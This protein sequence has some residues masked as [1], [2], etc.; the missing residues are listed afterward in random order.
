VPALERVRQRVAVPQS[1]RQQTDAQ[2]AVR[3]A[4]ERQGLLE[5]ADAAVRNLSLARS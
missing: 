3:I 5:E 1:P 4:Q 2:V